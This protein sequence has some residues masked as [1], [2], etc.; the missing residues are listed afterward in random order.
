MKSRMIVSF[1]TVLVSGLYF[2]SDAEA[3]TQTITASARN[4]TSTQGSAVTTTFSTV[5]CTQAGGGTGVSCGVKGPGTFGTNGFANLNVGES[6]G[7]T[8]PGTILLGCNG[9]YS[10]NGGGLS[11]TAKIEDTV[12]K[13]SQTISASAH[14]GSTIQGSAATVAPVTVTCTSAS[15]GTSGTTC[16]IRGPGT[17]GTNGYAIVAVGQS[18]GTTGGGDISLGC[19][20]SYSASGG[21]LTC[22]AL[23]T[24][25]C[26]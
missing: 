5:T 10:A 24:Q 21:G 9:S 19:N 26:P 16:G 17:F 8:G 23:V 4:G 2:A 7:T 1:L 18:V 25:V 3:A 11:C 13:P 22:S 15:G 20:G 14:N 12:C 6:V